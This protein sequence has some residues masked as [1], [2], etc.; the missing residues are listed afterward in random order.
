MAESEAQSTPSVDLTAWID[1]HRQAVLEAIRFH[2]GSAHTTEIREYGSIPRGS[3]DHHI[4]LLE[5]PPASLRAETDVEA[6]IEE[7]GRVDVGQP[8]LAREF[9]L[10][11]D[12]ER[13][14]ER[15][16]SSPGVR[17]SD[18]QDLLVRVNE[19]EDER[20]AANERVAELESEVDRMQEA[21]N[22]MVDVI[23]DLDDGTVEDSA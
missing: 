19:L 6:L 22:D 21:Y 18:V 23:R 9:E 12:G 20:D 5:D 7:S 3:F 13:L 14:L 16:E 15:V 11:A 2:N 4:S 17:A 10:T 1:G 8:T